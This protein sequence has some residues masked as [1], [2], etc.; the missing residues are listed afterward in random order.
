MNNNCY[1]K[2]TFIKKSWCSSFK[3]A[4]FVSFEFFLPCDL[5]RKSNNMK[6]KNTNHQIHPVKR[7]TKSKKQVHALCRFSMGRS[8][9]ALIPRDF[10]YY[11]NLTLCKI[12]TNE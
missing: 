1:N 3:E 6:G 11:I 10:L 8:Q 5:L 7:Y 9:H 2:L 4:Q 12:T